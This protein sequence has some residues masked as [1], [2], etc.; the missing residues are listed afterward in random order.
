M[1]QT[2]FTSGQI[3]NGSTQLED[4]NDFAVS[5]DTGLSVFI[6]L[7]TYVN[8]N[9]VNIKTQQTV[10]L[11]DNTT[12][13][14]ELDTA[15]VASANTSSFSLGEL[16]LAEVVTSSGSISTITDKRTWLQI[17]GALKSGC[18]VFHSLNQSVPLLT[19]YSVLFNSER[20]DTDNMHDTTTNTDRITFNTA[21][22]YAI[23][24]HISYESNSTGVSRDINIRKNGT[25]WIGRHLQAEGGGIS[26][27]WSL[28]VGTVHEFIVND[29]ITVTT[30]HDA[31][32]AI[33][34]LS[35]GNYS[36]EFAA[37]RVG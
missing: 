28:T 29:F 30:L 11:T 23:S 6:A 1:T 17:D 33:S 10:S 18:R 15:G 21:G 8:D 13:F 9:V 7:G 34:L 12:N 16:P 14:V 2:N 19:N 22:T 5:V 4:F 25:T 24:A 26:K 35:T 32:T 31:S 20:Y 36:A 27:E 3:K 37:Q